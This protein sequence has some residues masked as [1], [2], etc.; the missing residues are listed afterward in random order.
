MFSE[1]FLLCFKKQHYEKVFFKMVHIFNKD[2]TYILAGHFADF[3]NS[4]YNF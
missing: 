1:W 3:I 2:G 4:M